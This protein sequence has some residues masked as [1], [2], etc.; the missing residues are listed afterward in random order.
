MILLRFYDEEKKCSARRNNM[1]E[2]GIETLREYHK[3]DLAYLSC[4]RLIE[5]CLDN[6][7]RTCLVLSI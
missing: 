3:K 4:A 5:Y 2:I 6:G 7:I 1:M